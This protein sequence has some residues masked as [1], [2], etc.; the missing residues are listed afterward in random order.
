MFHTR[1]VLS[2]LAVTMRWPSGENGGAAST[3]PRV[4]FERGQQLAVAAVPHS[5]RLVGAGGDD[6][7]AVGRERRVQD[8]VR[9]AFELDQRVAP[10]AA[11][12]T[13]A[14]LS[15]LAVTMRWPSG[16]NA[17]CKTAAACGLRAWPAAGRWRRSTP[18]PSCPS[19]AVTM[20]WPSGENAALPDTVRRGLRAW[21]SSWPP[22]RV[23]HPR[24]LV[25]TGGDDAL[26]VGR[27]RR[28]HRH[29]PR[30]L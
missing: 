24:R 14:V 5:R 12:H 7:L 19:L 4:A 8:T 9:V 26:A 6:A 28:V 16:E 29:C 30:G 18:A 17:A 25:P 11:F 22:S 3:M 10:L 15:S 21:A 13:R 20:R 23:P 27:E 1:A 2:P